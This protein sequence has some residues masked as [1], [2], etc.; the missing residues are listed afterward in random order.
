MKKGNIL[1]VT[2]WGF[3]EGLIQSYTLPYLK[4][5]H[6]VNPSA[7]IYLITQEKKGLEKNKERLSVVSEELK[8]FNIVLLPEKYFRAG[9]AKYFSSAIHFFRHLSVIFFKSVSYIHSFCTPAGSYAYILSKFTGKRL[10]IDSYEPHAEYMLECGVWNDQ[11]FAFK[12]LNSLEKRQAK[13]ADHLIATTPGMVAHT[14]QKFG[15]AISNWDVNPACVDLERFCYNAEKSKQVRK[16]LGFDDKIVCVYAGKFGDFYLKEEVFEFYCVAFNYWKERF[17]V[18]LLSDLPS[19][20][21]DDFCSQFG[22]DRGRFTLIHSPHHLVPVYLS[23][24]DFGLSPYRPTPSK[25]FCTPIKNGE[26]W[27]V[28]L[29]VVITKDISVDSDLIERENIGYVLKELS[30]K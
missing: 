4:I 19:E 24:A 3:E 16:E 2:H 12:M 28:G 17:Q 22:L 26:Y 5:I 11:Q 15:I 29:P 21:L 23:A 25:K 30:D 8:A 20:Q 1:V 10:I 13:R 27:A 6:K 9:F 14:Q 7:I 18:L